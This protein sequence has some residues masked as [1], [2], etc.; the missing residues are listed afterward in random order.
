MVSLPFL[1]LPR[2]PSSSLPSLPCADAQGWNSTL[3]DNA[4][5]FRMKFTVADPVASQ[6]PPSP[7]PLNHSASAL[8]ESGV[9]GISHGKSRHRSAMPCCA[10]AKTIRRPSFHQSMPGCPQQPQHHIPSLTENLIRALNSAISDAFVTT[11]NTGCSSIFAPQQSCPPS[12]ITILSAVA[13]KFVKL[14]I[15]RSI[16]N[17][18]STI[19]FSSPNQTMPSVSFGLNSTRLTDAGGRPECLRNCLKCESNNFGQIGLSMGSDSRTVSLPSGS[20]RTV[21]SSPF[22]SCP[23]CSQYR[24]F[25]QTRPDKISRDK[26]RGSRLPFP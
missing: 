3:L 24:P 10:D 16:S 5:K 12:R 9:N 7:R 1:L 15:D 18:S 6:W 8:T 19:T 25:Q 23:I 14:P 22:F 11:D 17:L 20:I 21:R 26:F 4:R 2:T 13:I